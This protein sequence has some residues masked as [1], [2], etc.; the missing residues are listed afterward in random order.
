MKSTGDNEVPPN[1]CFCRIEIL[2]PTLSSSKKTKSL[3][4]VH[5]HLS[6]WCFFDL[7]GSSLAHFVP[8]NPQSPPQCWKRRL[9]LKEVVTRGLSDDFN[10]DKKQLHWNPKDNME[11]V[12]GM[13]ETKFYI[14]KIC[15][16]LKSI[17]WRKWWGA[18]NQVRNS[19]FCLYLQFCWAKKKGAYCLSNDQA[20]FPAYLA[21]SS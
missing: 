11:E 12:G 20:L 17:S 14:E 18:R 16:W 10:R 19:S 7:Q 5:V 4:T 2:G 6:L 13:Q 1:C 3:P 15:I 8:Q 9:K 21:F